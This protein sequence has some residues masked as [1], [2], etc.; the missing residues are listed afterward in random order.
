[1]AP[2]TW[3]SRISH[4]FLVPIPALVTALRLDGSTWSTSF[5]WAAV[6]VGVGIVPPLLMLLAER[7]RRGDRDWYVTVREQRSGLYALGLGCLV[8]LLLV[9]WAAGAPRLLVPSLVA[10]LVA[11]G[12]GALVNRRTKISVHVGAATGCALLLAHVAPRTAVPLLALVTAVAW[13][14]LRLGQHTP[15]QVALGAAVAAASLLGSLAA[16]GA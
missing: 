4:P 10:A 11:T 2:A 5:K 16:F 8:V 14:R 13:S 3:I 15:S 9:A 12:I 7:R 1:M 6:C